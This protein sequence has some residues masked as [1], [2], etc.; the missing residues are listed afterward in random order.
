MSDRMKEELKAAAAAE[1]A[2]KRALMAERKRVTDAAIAKLVKT[3]AYKALL[4]KCWAA[5]ERLCE[6]EQLYA[7]ET[8]QS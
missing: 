1:R 5:T 6:I 2:T 4:R 8:G 7:A 3:P